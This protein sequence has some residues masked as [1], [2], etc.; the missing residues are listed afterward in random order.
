MK[1]VKFSLSIGYAN[2]SHEEVFE[3]EDDAT[4]KDIEEDYICW[5]DNYLDGGWWV[6][7]E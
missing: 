2:A 6:L 1:R 3:F 5:R 4:E 7:D